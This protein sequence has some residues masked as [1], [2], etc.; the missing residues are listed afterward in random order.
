M[1]AASG[2]VLFFFP[3]SKV[4]QAAAHE[5]HTR[6][7]LLYI[8]DDAGAFARL[9]D[10]GPERDWLPTRSFMRRGATRTGPWGVLSRR[11]ST[12]RRARS[13]HARP[14]MGWKTLEADFGNPECT[15][16]VVFCHAPRRI[17]LIAVTQ[18]PINPALKAGPLSTIICQGRAK[19]PIFHSSSPCFQ[20]CPRQQAAAVR[21][22]KSGSPPIERLNAMF[23]LLARHRY[24][25]APPPN[26]KDAVAAKVNQSRR[27][28]SLQIIGA[29][30]ACNL[31][32]N[33]KPPRM[34]VRGGA[35]PMR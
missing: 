27:Q 14:W 30:A 1:I 32:A 28:Q 19:A 21:Q 4:P 25:A 10:R 11:Q 17:R 31:H 18:N 3:S 24:D 23:S 13:I 29:V 35:G 16:A 8:D 12:G 15:T 20:V 9:V 2:F 5:T 6:P 33:S 26:A 34:T 7:T 22:C